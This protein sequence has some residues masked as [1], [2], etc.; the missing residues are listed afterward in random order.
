MNY[1]LS[2]RLNFI[3]AVFIFLSIAVSAG[4]VSVE[5]GNILT[6]KG[7]ELFL[8]LKNTEASGRDYRLVSAGSAGGIGVGKFAVYD[9]TAGSARLTIDNNGNVG[10]GITNPGAKLHVIGSAIFGEF[11]TSSLA[12]GLFNSM[13]ILWTLVGK[14]IYAQDGLRSDG[15]ILVDAGNVGIGTT[16]PTNLLDVAG[17]AQ[18]GSIYTESDILVDADGLAT[19]NIGAP[20][21]IAEND[22]LVSVK[23]ADKL[24]TNSLTAPTV[25]F[26]DA[27]TLD[28]TTDANPT[29]TALLG[30]VAAST[31]Y[32]AVTSAW[33]FQDADT[34]SA[35]DSGEDIYID[36]FPKGKYNTGKIC[37]AGD[38]KTA[39]TDLG[40][41]K[42]SGDDIYNLNIGKVGIGTTGPAY[43]LDVVGSIKTSDTFLFSDGSTQAVA[44]TPNGFSWSVST[45]S[46]LQ[47][48]SVAA[49]DTSP[50]GLFFKPDGTKMYVIGEIG[51]DINEYNL[52]TPW[53]VSTALFLQSFSVAAQDTSP[54]G[55]FF[56]PDGRKMYVLGYIGGDVNEYNLATPW[57]VST[58]L[59]LQ[60]FSVATQETQPR[61]VFFKPDG[62]KMY[63]LGTVGDDVNEYDLSTPWSVSTASFLQTFSVAA[64]DTGPTA[65][66]FKPDGTKMYVVGTDGDDV[67]EYN[68]GL[69][70]DGDA[71]FAKGNVKIS[72]DP[73]L[74][75]SPG[76]Y[77]SDS[78]TAL[79]MHANGID[80][81]TNFEDSSSKN[82]VMTAA[83]NAQKDTSV[84]KLGLASAL[85]DGNGDYISV[86]D[87]SDW[88]LGAS[89]GGDF[90]IDVWVNFASISNIIQYIV[91]TNPI[92][93]SQNTPGWFL[94]WDSASFNPNPP[95]VRFGYTTG[96]GQ[97][98][99]G[100][101]ADWSPSANT[102]Y[103]MALVR[104]AGTLMLYIDGTRIISIPEG[105]A[106]TSGAFPLRIGGIPDG[107]GP[108]MTGRLDELRI[109][110]VARWNGASFTPSNNPI[111]GGGILTVKG[112]MNAEKLIVGTIDPVY[113]IDGKRYATYVSDYSGGVMVETGGTI[114]IG[115][116]FTHIIDFDHLETGTDLW[117]F[118]EVSNKN[119]EE[120]V[121]LLTPGFAEKSWYIK[122]GN[123]LIIYGLKKDGEIS[124]RLM[125]PRKDHAN[126]PT[127]L[128]D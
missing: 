113:D 80:G 109:S 49:Q 66:S 95:K 26:I 104:S 18:F 63:V 58:A 118:W 108:Y 5:T 123:K 100:L 50:I 77:A 120:M 127:K 75:A 54:T 87:S 76:Q 97:W 11:G 42:A 6:E 121:V 60:S 112:Q 96:P 81:N 21:S 45:A 38:C 124:Y 122:S 103:H 3:L 99:V 119:I 128:N 9:A 126:W 71:I 68:L 55:I 62:A 84:V 106:I 93:S 94:A 27:E 82:H 73:N 51:D 12:G 53:D 34:D 24:C 61:G 33:A 19:P 91:G 40:K 98:P 117:L 79:L 13:D 4:D 36:S 70:V 83:G 89:S 37:L 14:R 59:F 111:T 74:L 102:W 52:A 32:T 114:E 35:Y 44:A 107:P 20:A 72:Y 69:D 65:L 92:S 1:I 39:W 8:S 56:K 30:T 2:L 115:D 7:N 110:S 17:T 78:K 85:F 64:Q 23:S 86:P 57:D 46:F 67:N 16:T 47:S 43:K 28:C 25:V 125:A 10:I 88:D 105:D 31:T 90:T 41:W 48:F 101:L 22:V 29:E 116:A 15:D